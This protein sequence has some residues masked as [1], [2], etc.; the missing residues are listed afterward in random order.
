MTKWTVR[1]SSRLYLAVVLPPNTELTRRFSL[2]F[3]NKTFGTLPVSEWVSDW[4]T[5]RQTRA[6]TSTRLSKVKDYFKYHIS[7]QRIGTITSRSSKIGLSETVRL[8]LKLVISI[9][10]LAGQ[11]KQ[12]GGCTEVRIGNLQVKLT[13][14][15]LCW[16]RNG[17]WK[18]SSTI[19]FWGSSRSQW[20]LLISVLFI[21]T[22]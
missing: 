5:D 18:R 15:P 8:L 1:I 20:G 17:H 19:I 22:F 13:P 6:N 9:G 12:E 7:I 2:S 14:V 16:T 3:G 21:L 4:V 11:S 10:N